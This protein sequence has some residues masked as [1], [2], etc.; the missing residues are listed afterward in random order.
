M[1]SAFDI[2]HS[3][4][5]PL[6]RKP[7]DL[8]VLVENVQPLYNRDSKHRLRVGAAVSPGDYERIEALDKVYASLEKIQFDG[9]QFRT[10][11][12]RLHFE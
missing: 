3:S 7:E 5:F 6:A 1:H 11:I 4:S 9:A 10:D 12:G 2:R 8:R